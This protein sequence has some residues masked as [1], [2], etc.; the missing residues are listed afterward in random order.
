MT[1]DT[2]ALSN[3]EPVFDGMPVII[4]LT[5]GTDILCMLYQSK[6]ET[7][8][9]MIMERPLR[10]I[11]EELAA[12]LQNSNSA[13]RV[14]SGETIYTKVRTRF[15]RWMTLSDA[16]MF[17]IFSDH[18]ISIAPLSTE[19]VNAY[20]EWA[21]QLYGAPAYHAKDDPPNPAAVVPSPKSSSNSTND[22]KAS[23]HD[24]ILHNYIPKGKPS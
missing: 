20:M 19:Y 12:P 23:Y 4:R 15:D 3:L 6:D 5:T 18:V 9:R 10:I 24:F 2:L 7:D 16:A 1:D 22:T 21:E 13:D 8:L 17:P 14:K 11:S